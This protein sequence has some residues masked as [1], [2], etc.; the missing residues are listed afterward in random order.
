MAALFTWHLTGGLSCCLPYHQYG[1]WVAG[2]WPTSGGLCTSPTG[3]IC[4]N[5]VNKTTTDALRAHSQ[6]CLG[7]Q[8]LGAQGT[9]SS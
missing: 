3:C 7:R 6:V 1:V 2:C 5:L 8:S 4:I 9:S